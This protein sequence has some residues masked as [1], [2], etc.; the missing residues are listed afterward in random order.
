MPPR[1][2]ICCWFVVTIHVNPYKQHWNTAIHLLRYLA[3][4]RNRGILFTSKSHVLDAIV[5]GY[6][7]A[8]LGGC[9]DTRKSTSG[10]V[11]ISSG[12]A[13]SWSSKKQS[14]TAQ[15]TV[16]AEYIALS[17]AAREALWLRQLCNE[18]QHT[19]TDSVSLG[20]DNQGCIDLTEQDQLTENS[21]HIDLKFHFL[22]DHVQAGNITLKYVPTDQMPADFFIKA[23]LKGKHNS[24]LRMI[25][26]HD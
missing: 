15:S 13:I 8:D 21:K 3:G 17:F 2:I 26:M 7:D 10:S 20:V 12:G 1:H 16:E 23:L 19:T 4:S 18:T 6:S 24:N 14:L 9:R 25:R 11:F 5:K 22:K